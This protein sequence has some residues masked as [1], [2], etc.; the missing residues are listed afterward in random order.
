MGDPNSKQLFK[1]TIIINKNIILGGK[2]WKK[3]LELF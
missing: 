3:E 2:I 1:K